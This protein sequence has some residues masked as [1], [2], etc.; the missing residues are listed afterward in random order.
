MQILNCMNFKVVGL[1]CAIDMETYFQ[2]DCV[3]S[4]Y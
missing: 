1:V 4:I 2:L 3:R